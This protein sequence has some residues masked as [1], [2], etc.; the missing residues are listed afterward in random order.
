M[1]IAPPSPHVCGFDAETISGTHAPFE[2]QP[3]HFGTGAVHAVSTPSTTTRRELRI[4]M[5]CLRDRGGLT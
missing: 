3:P 5:A 4:S 1:H 2:R